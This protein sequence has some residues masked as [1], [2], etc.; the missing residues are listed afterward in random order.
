M[1][2]QGLLIAALFFV[3]SPGVLLTLGRGRRMS[4]AIHAVVFVVVGAFLWRVLFGAPLF[5]AYEDCHKADDCRGEG[6]ACNPVVQECQD[7]Y[8][9]GCPKMR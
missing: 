3:L 5:E 7:Q 2:K 9:I 1:Y 6:R 4:A 8:V